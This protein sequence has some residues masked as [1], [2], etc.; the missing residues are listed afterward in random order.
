MSAAFSGTAGFEKLAT[1]DTTQL[2]LHYHDSSLS[3]K[4]QV[5]Q[6]NLQAGDRAPDVELAD[7]NWL[8]DQL[9]GT[10][11]KLLA[12][13]KCTDTFQ[14]VKTIDVTDE[15]ISGAYGLSSGGVLIRPD[16]YIALIAA[17][18]DEVNTYFQRFE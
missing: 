13:E 2:N 7:G 1:K 4:K 5:L 17:S 16:G 10:Q 15:K 18:I 11:W 9:K 6:N 8:S 14:N 3:E 12:F